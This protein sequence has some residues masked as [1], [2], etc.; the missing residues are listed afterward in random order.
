MVGLV[1]Q[2]S[3]VNCFSERAVV[4][5]PVAQLV[6]GKL[7]FGPRIIAE[8]SDGSLAWYAHDLPLSESAAPWNESAP[9]KFSFSL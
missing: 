8:R 9:G 5:L 3:S 2:V 6:N 7:V 1:I 4:L